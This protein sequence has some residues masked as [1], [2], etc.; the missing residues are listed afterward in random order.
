MK[1][2]CKTKYKQRER[3]RAE[4]RQ[5][6]RDTTD[7][8]WRAKRK[9][10]VI[11]RIRVGDQHSGGGDVGLGA[12][13]QSSGDGLCLLCLSPALFF[14]SLLLFLPLSLMSSPPSPL[15]SHF[16]FCSALLSTCLHWS[17]YII[18]SFC[19]LYAA[20][21][22]LLL[23]LFLVSLLCS[24]MLICSSR[25]SFPLICYFVFQLSSPH[26]ISSPFSSLF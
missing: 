14:Y 2:W 16:V 9:E 5:G 10:C 19:H 17:K 4:N 11:Q 15:S 23:F 21:S 26:S 12:W 7:K 8:P 6:D 18:S 24:S 25:P 13:R 3:Q 20:V 22:S 1:E